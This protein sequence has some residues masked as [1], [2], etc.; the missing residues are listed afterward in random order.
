MAYHV[1]ITK[2]HYDIQVMSSKLDLYLYTQRRYRI[3]LQKKRIKL[4][5]HKSF[6]YKYSYLYILLLLLPVLGFFT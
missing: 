3:F 5:S 1:K 6:S 2:L 4:V